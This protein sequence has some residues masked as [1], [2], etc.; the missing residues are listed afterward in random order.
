MDGAGGNVIYR[1]VLRRLPVVLPAMDRAAV[2]RAIAAL[3]ATPETVTQEQIEHA[4]RDAVFPLIEESEHGLRLP[5][6][7]A[8]LITTDHADRLRSI[9]PTAATLVGLPP[10]CDAVGQPIAALAGLDECVPLIAS[11]HDDAEVR[12]AECVIAADGR[13]VQCVSN[14]RVASDGT[15]LGVNTTVQDITL[16]TA[17]STQVGQLYHA[18]ETRVRELPAL[19]EIARIVALATS[20]D[21]TLAAI[22]ERTTQIVGCRAAAIFLPDATGQLRLMGEYGLPDGYGEIV[23]ALMRATAGM[24][25]AAQTPTLRAYWDGR[26]SFETLVEIPPD[27][28]ESLHAT[29]AIGREH[30]WV[31]VLAVPL[32]VQG[33]PTGTLTCYLAEADEP[34]EETMRLIAAIAD[35]SA[36]A[37]R[38][39]ALYAETERQLAE[40]T[41]LHASARVLNSSLDR[42][43][44]LH[45]IVEQAARVTG[46]Q[47][48]SLHELTETGDATILR[49]AYS[50]APAWKTDQTVFPQGPALH[51][52][53]TRAP[54]ILRS[55]ED[56]RAMPFWQP[57]FADRSTAMPLRGL[58]A[59]PFGYQRELNAALT[60][61]FDH[62][63]NPTEGEMQLLATFA[64]HAGVAMHNAHLYEQAQAVAAVEERNRLAR[65]LHDSVTQSLFSMSLL[66]QVLPTLWETRPQEARASLDELRRLTRESLA[67]M[68]ALLFQL[69]PV[70]LEEDGLVGALTKHIES[71]QRRDGPRLTFSATLGDERLPLRTEEALFRV[72]TEA[73]GNALKHAR[74]ATVETTLTAAD[75]HVTLTVRD[76]GGGFDPAQRRAEPG[77]LGLPGMRERVAREGGAVTIASAPGAGTTVTVELTFAERT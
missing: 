44:V 27:A 42:A 57:E 64:D 75:H 21:A 43:A 48:S 25:D 55:R 63:I 56:A 35:Q 4:L 71:L 23:A 30:G 10:G 51:A 45:R 9:T 5:P 13:R 1:N 16:Q 31:S 6:P 28:P 74:A 52:I 33:R 66:A 18:S 47:A 2:D 38:N 58:V 76:D 59:V 54:V 37:V 24:P 50:A 34:P 73:I 3:G 8:G 22:T 77:H 20:L 32:V 46:A 26:P 65:D 62:E 19:A 60:L 17:I 61:F 7:R 29:R 53:R 40:M 70:A 11:F 49:A 67:E 68:R 14:L 12:A 39:S 36:I 69:R 72:A 15:V 41:A